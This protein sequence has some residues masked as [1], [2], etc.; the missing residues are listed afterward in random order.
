MPSLASHILGLPL[1]LHRRS[2]DVVAKFVVVAACLALGTGPAVADAADAQPRK[3]NIVL[4]LADD[5]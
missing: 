1:P 3:P 4:I 5:K 2:S